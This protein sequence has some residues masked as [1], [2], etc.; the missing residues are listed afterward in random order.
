MAKKKKKRSKKSRTP[1]KLLSVVELEAQA[2]ESFKT[3]NLR[4][5]VSAAQHLCERN[6]EHYEPLLCRARVALVE[7]L[8]NKGKMS[9]ARTA[10]APLKAMPPT[11][12]ID[13][14]ALH[15]A[16]ESGDFISVADTAVRLLTSAAR[17]DDDCHRLQKLRAADVL[18]LSFADFPASLATGH[19]ELAAEL[20]QVHQALELV[21][22]QSYNEALAAVIS[23]GRRSLFAPWRLYIKGLVAFYRGEDEKAREA[24]ARLPEDSWLSGAASPFL[25]L[26]LPLDNVRCRQLAKDEARLRDVC[27][28]A[29]QPELAD[30]LPRANYLWMTG[31]HRDSFRYL[32]RSRIK[33]P[34]ETPNIYGSLTRF[35]YNA[36]FSLG[37]EAAE[38]YIDFVLEKA[39]KNPEKNQIMI[40]QGLRIAVLYFEPED[41][42]GCEVISLWQDFIRLQQHFYGENKRLTSMIYAHLGEFF[43]REMVDEPGMDPFQL[44][45]HPDHR[46][47]EKEFFDPEEAERYFLLSVEEDAENRQAWLALL[48]L[49]DGAGW[50]S[51]RNRLLDDIV[52]R[53]PDDQETLLKAGTGCWERKALHKGR[54]YFQRALELNPQDAFLQEKFLLVTAAL[55]HDQV[56]KG[57][58]DACHSLLAE[59]MEVAR[60]ELDN[61][62]CGFSYLLGRWSVFFLMVNEERE[63][64]D[65]YERARSLAP[66]PDKFLY[67]TWVYG[68]SQGLGSRSLS[69]LKKPL[70]KLFAAASTET[71]LDFLEV[72]KYGCRLLENEKYT[73]PRLES[74]EKQ[75]RKLLAKTMRNADNRQVLEVIEYALDD[76]IDG[77][78]LIRACLHRFKAINARSPYYLFYEYVARHMIKEKPPQPEDIVLFREILVLAE[79][80]RDQVLIGRVKGQLERFE[81][82]VKMYERFK[83]F[84]DDPDDYV[85]EEDLDA[86]VGGGWR[87]PLPPGARQAPSS[88]RELYPQPKKKDQ[89]T[90]A[91]DELTEAPSLFDMFDD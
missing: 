80:T 14:L 4:Q 63:A 46:S 48:D 50:K 91:P 82:L 42:D 54:K 66:N 68:L 3:G 78:R 75:L 89:P 32:H 18:V 77:K 73:S 71:A 38:S 60:P 72:F 26:L 7:V 40:L 28:L 88:W 87:M 83:E 30:I 36:V 33:F 56:C 81:S 59:V 20:R 41:E 11:P 37:N 35:Y 76:A 27:L 85:D 10:F 70:Q 53:F 17:E 8:L 45:R 1:E 44:L 49:Y 84:S 19:P 79:E 16:R 43:A 15:L 29:G 23:L 86:D 22:Q 64:W 69:P 39:T 9:Q 65:C 55:A 12:E 34:T 90:S 57:H 25:L 6:R 62:S 24:F 74:E 61:I 13:D 52:K 58:V 21:C 51:K 2:A 5:A 67:F 47:D 31:R